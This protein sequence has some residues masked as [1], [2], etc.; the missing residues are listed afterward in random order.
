MHFP[1]EPK[2][3]LPGAA[4]NLCSSAPLLLALGRS[5]LLGAATPDI[6]ILVL[7]SAKK[8]ISKSAAKQM[9]TSFVILQRH[10]YI[11]LMKR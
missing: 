1:P 11:F 10:H 8:P 9:Y 4:V 6:D 7:L 3:P 5:P 2:L